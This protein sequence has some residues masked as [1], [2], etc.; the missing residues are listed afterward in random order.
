MEIGTNANNVRAWVC[1]C[2]GTYFSVHLRRHLHCYG[3]LDTFVK[4]CYY[5]SVLYIF[6][7]L[8][9]DFFVIVKLVIA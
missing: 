8:H 6:W 1:F 7:H 2:H 3:L 4:A 5:K 9:A